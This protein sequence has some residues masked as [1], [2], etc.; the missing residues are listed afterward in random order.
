M[1]VIELL[2]EKSAFFSSTVNFNHQAIAALDFNLL[3][4]R[5]AVKLRSSG[6]YGLPS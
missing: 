2:N 3:K 6:C 5:T 4:E 1:I